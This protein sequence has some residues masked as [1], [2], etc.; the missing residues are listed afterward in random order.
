[1][2]SN[3]VRFL[4][5][6]GYTPEYIVVSLYV[7]FIVGYSGEFDIYSFARNI[8]TSIPLN[9]VFSILKVL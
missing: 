5:R 8:L 6:I 3:P 7:N 2:S 9:L 4:A 1:M